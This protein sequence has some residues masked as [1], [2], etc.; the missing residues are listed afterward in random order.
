MTNERAKE[1]LEALAESTDPDVIYAFLEVYIIDGI[2]PCI[3]AN[4][5]CGYSTDLE[6]DSR[7]GYCEECETHSVISCIELMIE[8][9]LD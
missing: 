4:G 3:C 6:S 9:G 5:D 1:L 8:G 2:V 7:E